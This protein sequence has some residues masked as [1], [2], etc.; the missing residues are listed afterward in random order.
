MSP[1]EPQ[2]PRPSAADN[3]TVPLGDRTMSLS[4]F[5]G[6]TDSGGS[7][8]QS[9]PFS[10]ATTAAPGSSTGSGLSSSSF[11][12]HGRFVPGTIVAGRYRIVAMA[13]KGGMGEVYRAD[14]L[15]VGQTVALKFLPPGVA[16]DP[17]AV[18]RLHTEVRLARE[19]AHPNVC[20]VYDVGEVDGTPFLSMQYVDGENL[21][22]LLRRIDRLPHEK[23][24]D[25]ARQLATGIAAAHDRNVLHRDLKPAN[26]MLDERGKLLVTDFGLSAAA[27]D[28]GAEKGIVGTPAY[29]APEQLAGQPATVRSDLY[30][31]GLLMYELFTGRP[32]F[33]ADTYDALMRQRERFDPGRLAESMERVEVPA[34]VVRMVLRCLE[35]DP[36]RRP[37]SAM[38][39]LAALPGGDPLAAALAAGETPTPEMVAAAGGTGAVTVRRAA[40]LLAAVVLPVIVLALLNAAL[41]EAAPPVPVDDD[42]AVLVDHARQ[43]LKS[44]GHAPEGAF[45]ASGVEWDRAFFAYRDPDVRA[46][47]PGTRRHAGTFWY[48]QSARRLVPSYLSM[49]VTLTDPP[50]A[51][52]MV[53][54]VLGPGRQLLRFTAVGPAYMP[55][56][57]GAAE[58]GVA[59]PDSFASGGLVSAAGPTARAVAKP[60]SVPPAA[61][62]APFLER[63]QLGD[64]AALA[65]AEP[66]LNPPVNSDRRY[67][68]TV[69]P[70]GGGPARSW[71][72]PVRVEAASLAGR[73]VHFAVLRPWEVPSAGGAVSDGA[74]PA[75]GPFSTAS[76]ATAPAGRPW[77]ERAFDYVAFVVRLTL[78][79]AAAALAIR[80][81]RAGRSDRRNAFRLGLAVFALH[82]IGTLMRSAHVPPSVA[83]NTVVFNCLAQGIFRGAMAWLFYLALE[84]YVRRAW[85]DWLIS[86]TRLLGGMTVR[87]PL[88]GR[89]V[90]GGLA[91][92][93]VGTALT[94][95]LAL[96]AV[97]GL[98]VVP[99]PTSWEIADA[100]RSTPSIVAVLLWN[101]SFAAIAASAIPFV[102]AAI[103]H[104][105]G[106][107]RAALPAAGAFLFLLM[108]APSPAPA[109][110]AA[111]MGLTAVTVLVGVVA[112]LWA[113]A[114][115]GVLGLAA[116]SLALFALQT[117]PPIFDATAWYV[118]AVWTVTSALLLMAGAAFVLSTG[119]RY[120]PR[121]VVTT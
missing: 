102:A 57:G 92:A 99:T 52:G 27:A 43:T 2:Q 106:S 101:V 37:A 62:W 1:S 79:V 107:R 117:F 97:K 17:V 72:A 22:T 114:R 88:V 53:T 39:V 45:S 120:E 105:T 74:G 19:V 23:A 14:D 4:D 77:Y 119:T 90:L 94:A 30:A 46:A 116:C 44:L 81:A 26:V 33:K 66:L 110:S 84:P 121:G 63:A 11:F 59:G 47:G 95:G 41:H 54:L 104:T 49:P 35:R 64:P 85:P 6:G 3:P 58:G 18:A 118:G 75:T 93:A 48:R 111:G 20:R 82:T 15:R 78:W 103:F 9:P 32:V 42:P 70:R 61:D 83:E 28:S 76:G 109:A 115:Y 67:A 69:V 100:M 21:A 112:R 96:A 38:A 13:G 87:D 86:W 40:P 50:L 5:V 51:P 12:N 16:V 98:G 89:D 10:N 65:P 71:A 108:F 24:E 29:M 34:S 55:A 91:V 73:P 31:L 25:L 68:W 56:Q 80:N 36:L 60:A 113:L 8:P 7:A